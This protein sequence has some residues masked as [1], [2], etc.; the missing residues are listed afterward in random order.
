MN[1]SSSLSWWIV[2]P[3]VCYHFSVLFL[4]TSFLF[5]RCL[6]RKIKTNIKKHPTQP[7]LQRD[8]FWQKLSFGIYMLPPPTH[9][10]F[11][12]FFLSFNLEP[13][14]FCPPTEIKCCVHFILSTCSSSKVNLLSVIVWS[15]V[16]LKVDSPVAGIV[17]HFI[18]D[19]TLC[20]WEFLITLSV[21]GNHVQGSLPIGWFSG[22]GLHEW[23]PFVIFH[24]RSRE[25]SQCHFLT[26][27]LVGVASCCV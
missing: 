17:L 15:C 27:F 14:C 21:Y 7:H 26:D 23:M 22:A 18:S 4:Q 2:Q 3:A 5:F 16:V 25:R 6:R 1:G 24:A 19:Y 11:F 20:L 12:F 10:V 13:L 9:H 8:C